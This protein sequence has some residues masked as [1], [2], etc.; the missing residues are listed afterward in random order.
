MRLSG[1][2]RSSLARPRAAPQFL[3][4]IERESEVEGAA[5]ASRLAAAAAGA[6]TASPKPVDE[7][8]D[9]GAQRRD[10]RAQLRDGGVRSH[11]RFDQGVNR[12]AG[13]LPKLAVLLSIFSSIFSR[14]ERS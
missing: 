10:L 1:S 6:V 11:L 5:R 3:E 2:I 13:F 12:L 8:I 9:L 14:S 4:E 7:A